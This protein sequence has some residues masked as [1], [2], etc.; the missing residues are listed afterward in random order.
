M[1]CRIFASPA[2]VGPMRG[3]RTWPLY[4]MAAGGLLS[5]GRLTSTLFPMFL[6]LAAILP[7]ALAPAL[8]AGLAMLQGLV[9]VLFYTWRGVY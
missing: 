2:S 5:I 7:A 1:S 3:E 6:A 8:V 4:P 9:A